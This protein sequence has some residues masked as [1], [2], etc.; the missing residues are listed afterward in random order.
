M[1][2]VERLCW[3][4]PIRGLYLPGLCDWLRKGHVIQVGPHRAQ[5]GGCRLRLRCAV[6]RCRET[7]RELAAGK[8]GRARRGRGGTSPVA[9]F[10]ILHPVAPEVGSWVHDTGLCS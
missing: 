6:A 2:G 1:G 9:A 7:A 5:G 3:V 4:W 10:K 8:E